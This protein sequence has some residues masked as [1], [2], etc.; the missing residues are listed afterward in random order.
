MYFLDSDDAITP[1]CIKKLW[2]LAEKYQAD[3]VLGDVTV[4]EEDGEKT[5][6]CLGRVDTECIKGN[7]NISRA[8]ANQVWYPMAWNKLVSKRFLLCHQLLFHPGI[9]HE[10]ELWSFTLASLADK[11]VICREVTYL[12]FKRGG[13]IMGSFS[14]KHI[15]DSLFIIKQMSD[16]ICIRPDKYLPAKIRTVSMFFIFKLL[17]SEYDDKFRK[18]TIRQLRISIDHSVKYA[19]PMNLKDAVRAL[20]LILP[21]KL[22]LVYVR[23]L[24]NLIF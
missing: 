16:I 3:F 9:Y 23:L 14:K 6:S 2:I 5:S 20:V 11:L 22:S 21:T 8:Y 15:D 18:Q 4:F 13:S 12:Y 17:L 7:S 10:D 19:F 24:K 1:D